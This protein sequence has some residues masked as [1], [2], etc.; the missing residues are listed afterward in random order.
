MAAGV[1]VVAVGCLLALPGMVQRYRW[2]RSAPPDEVARAKALA[3]RWTVPLLLA[4]TVGPL[5]IV[6]LGA[7]LSWVVPF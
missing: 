2:A 6:V 3:G 5:L 4:A 1:A 7:L